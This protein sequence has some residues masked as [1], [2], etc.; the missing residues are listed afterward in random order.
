MAP[1]DASL[2]ALTTSVHQRR[3]SLAGVRRAAVPIAWVQI[4]V[5]LAGLVTYPFVRA[6]DPDFWWH[7][8]TG[9]L[10]FHHGIPRHDPFSWTAAG[11]A[12]VAHEWLSEALIYAFETAF[13]YYANVLV[14]GAVVCAAILLMYRLGRSTG[15]GTRP[16]VLLMFVSVAVIGFYVTVRPQEFTWLLFAVFVYVLQR[17]D[18][19]EHAPLWLLPPLLAL[20][21]NLHLGFMYGLLLVAIW[22][23]ARF[24][25]RLRDTRI[26]LRMPVA[27]G[28]ACVAAAT[29]NPHGPAL[30]WYPARYVFDP[31]ITANIGEWQRPN[32]LYPLHA[33]IFLTL[34]LLALALISRTRP[35]LFLSLVTLTMIALSLQAAR[36]APFAALLLVPVAGG[37]MSRRWTAATSARDSRRRVPLTLAAAL[38]AA[39]G[40]AVLAIGAR[41]SGAV[42]FARPSE[43]G[44]PAAEAAYVRAHNPGA[45]LF[46]EYGDGGFLIYALY[47]RVKVGIDGRGDFYG[48]RLLADYTTI[49][50]ARDGWG[51]LLDAYAPDVVLIP[52]TAPLA[53]KLRSSATWRQ[54]FAGTD[55]V[56]FTRR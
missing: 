4:A 45:R 1:T 51:R 21:A 25:A 43:Q 33:P 49:Y 36:N 20:W 24:I 7:L 22:I 50:R 32:P 17:H 10:I 48:G 8:R 52:K 19:G 42:S 2:S 18:T 12:W 28:A 47:P 3:A 14:Y 55:E 16:L 11:H 15:A 41:Q 27:L 40:G 6:V 31:R 23:V 5:V 26:D 13:G 38:V 54:A 39:V 30:L 34:L 56:V 53:A 46:N 29:L 44:Y 35:R 37:A 9:E